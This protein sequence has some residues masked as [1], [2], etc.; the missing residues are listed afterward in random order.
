MHH[1]EMFCSPNFKWFFKYVGNFSALC[2][3]VY[4]AIFQYRLKYSFSLSIAVPLALFFILLLVYR[5]LL[6]YKFKLKNNINKA[7]D[8]FTNFASMIPSVD[9]VIV[10]ENNALPYLEAI[11]GA[12]RGSFNCEIGIMACGSIPERFAAPL[13]KDW[14]SDINTGPYYKHGLFSDQDFLT[15]PSKITAS[16]SAAQSDKLEIVQSESFI[17][18]G[19]A[20]L[21]VSRCMA[22]KFNLKEGFLSTDTIKHSVKRCILEA[23]K[24]NFPGVHSLPLCQWLT[25]VFNQVNVKINGP[26]VQVRIKNGMDEWNIY[27]AD[28]TFCIRCFEWP[29]ESKWLSRK[30]IWPDQRVV[31]TI[32]DIG[33][34]CSQKSKK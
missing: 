18:K 10:L 12:L 5:W 17:E 13:V 29:L 20:M 30:K 26:A 24:T 16:Y 32:K 3:V 11:K 6:R 15:E 2:L 27:L 1:Q 28:F 8:L 4:G 14:I 23:P 34:H 7:D 22:E 31:T 21:R 9:E 19:F 25:V 33:F